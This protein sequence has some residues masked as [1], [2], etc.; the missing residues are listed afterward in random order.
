MRRLAAGRGAGIQQA[1]G[2]ATGRGQPVQQQGGRHLR[3][4]VLHRKMTFGI[5]GQRRHRARRRQHHSL[6][7]HLICYDIHS[8]QRL[9]VLGWG[10]F[11]CI[12]PE[13]QRRFGIIGMQDGLPAVR[14]VL[15]HPVYPPLRVV[16]DRLRMFFRLGHQCVA[17]AQEAAQAAVDEAGLV[18]RG[19]VAL[20]GFHGLVHQ[21]VGGVTGTVALR[22]VAGS[23]VARAAFRTGQRQ[24]NT[25]QGV[26]LRWRRPLG[27]LLAQ[28]FGPAKPAQ[29]MKTQGLH[30]GPQAGVD[31]FERSGHGAAAANGHQ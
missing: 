20:G 19:L 16:P 23:R 9:Q 13:N 28:R 7:A 22:Q 5:P 11:S 15:A 17:L 25:Q 8:L 31:V 2:R 18:H 10:R 29:R 12:D 26:G 4:R 6:R 24:R 14:V 3:R 30:A 1:Q 21:R 27:Q